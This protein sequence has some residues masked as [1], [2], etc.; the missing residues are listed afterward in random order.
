MSF[1]VFLSVVGRYIGPL[2]IYMVIAAVNFIPCG[3][4][5]LKRKK[6]GFAVWHG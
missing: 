6:Q 3:L 1:S 4:F 2:I 5:F